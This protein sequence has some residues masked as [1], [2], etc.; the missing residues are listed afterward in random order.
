[1]LCPIEGEVV[2]NCLIGLDISRG[3]KDVMNAIYCNQDQ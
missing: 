3:V 2:I 1:M